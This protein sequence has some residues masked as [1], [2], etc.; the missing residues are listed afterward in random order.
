MAGYTE[1]GQRDT[2]SASSSGQTDKGEAWKGTKEQEREKEHE[3]EKSLSI[4]HEELWALQ[5][6]LGN[7]KGSLS[8]TF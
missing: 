8:S 3:K 6:I 2:H 7:K 1:W 5:R 4:T